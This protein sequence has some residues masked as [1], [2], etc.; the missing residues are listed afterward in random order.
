MYGE[1][2]QKWWMNPGL[3]NKDVCVNIFSS[4]CRDVSPP[5]LLSSCPLL[6]FASSPAISQPTHTHTHELCWY[7]QQDSSLLFYLLCKLL[8]DKCFILFLFFLTI[9]LSSLMC[10]STLSGWHQMPE[11]EFKLFEDRLLV[12]RL[13]EVW[14][15]SE[16]SK[17]SGWIL[18]L[19]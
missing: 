7:S 19:E 16:G 11:H 4:F 15:W 5:L 3:R 9:A 12:T 17:S 18:L 14:S 13:L 2:G 1:D 10:N 6:F 8:C